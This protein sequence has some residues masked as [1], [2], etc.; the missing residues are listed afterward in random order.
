MRVPYHDDDAL[1]DA[2]RQAAKTHDPLPSDVRDAGAVAWELRRLDD[3]LLELTYDSDGE[4]LEAAGVRSRAGARVLSFEFGDVTLE[5]EIEP[6]G[7]ERRLAGH[8]SPVPAG[9]VQVRHRRRVDDVEPDQHG[10]FRLAGV[11][12][13]PLSVRWALPDGRRLASTW[14][15]V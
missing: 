2:L 11:A 5:L 14:T 15:T 8:I 4:S 9:A 3:E 10:V 1:L 13:G 6:D 7:S 12:P